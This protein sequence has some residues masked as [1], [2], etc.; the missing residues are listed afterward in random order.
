MQQ[1]ELLPLAGGG[2]QNDLLA[3]AHGG[4]WRLAGL[5]GHVR[6]PG[7]LQAQQVDAAS[8]PYRRI[9]RTSDIGGRQ[10]AVETTSTHGSRAHWGYCWT[11]SKVVAGDETPFTVATI[12]KSP[13]GAE[14]GTWTA[15]W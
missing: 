3:C 9:A 4:L 2:R 12:G 13:F 15:I 8:H 11:V 14:V 1:D 5:G 6:E 10:D 7:L